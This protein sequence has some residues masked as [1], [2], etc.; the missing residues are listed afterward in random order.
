MLA[1]RVEKSI[2]VSPGDGRLLAEYERERLLPGVVA[3]RYPRL[4]HLLENGAMVRRQQLVYLALTVD[5]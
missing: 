1:P 3:H 5:G 4:L 2:L